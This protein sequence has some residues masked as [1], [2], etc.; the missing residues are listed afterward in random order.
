M[1]LKRTIGYDARCGGRVVSHEEDTARC[2]TCGLIASAWWWIHSGE[3]QT[4]PGARQGA[5]TT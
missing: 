2:T 4:H 5:G 3:L 1:S